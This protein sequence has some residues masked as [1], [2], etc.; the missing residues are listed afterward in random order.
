MPII[1]AVDGIFVD[2]K[3]RPVAVDP[4]G[5]FT[6]VRDAAT[7]ID[8]LTEAE[9]VDL[10]ENKGTRKVK[11]H[12]QLKFRWPTLKEVKRA[13][14]NMRVRQHT[15]SQARAC[16]ARM[17]TGKGKTKTNTN[18]DHRTMTSCRATWEL[19]DAEFETIVSRAPGYRSFLPPGVVSIVVHPVGHTFKNPPPA[20]H[21][22]HQTLFECKQNKGSV[23]I[24][25]SGVTR[26]PSPR[27]IPHAV[28]NNCTWS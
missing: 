15:P 26:V 20:R 19:T 18:V 7:C 24:K 9:I 14:P 8:S 4:L 1:N 12:G 6:S 25:Y 28:R 21:H 13:F 2:G 16:T 5:V 11:C 23:D 17:V 3:F 22:R 27:E 10:A